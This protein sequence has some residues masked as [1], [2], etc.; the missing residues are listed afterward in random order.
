MPHISIQWKITSLGSICLLCTIALLVSSSLYRAEVNLDLVKSANMQMLEDA[1][2]ARMQARAE[3]QA[4]AIQHYFSDVHHFGYQ[5]SRQVAQLR[6]QGIQNGVSPD[7]VRRDLTQLVRDA[8]NSNPTLLSLYVVFQ[9]D[10][11]DNQDARF[12]GA[13]A[14]G[15]NEH[16]R[17]SS[18][19]TRNGANLSGVPVAEDKITD[20]TTMLDGSAYNAWYECPKQTFAPCLLDPYFDEASGQRVLTTSLVFPLLENGKLLAVVGADISLSRLQQ[21]SLDGNRLLYEGQGSVRIV[22]PAG[23]IA[24]DSQDA[25][26]LGQPLTQVLSGPSLDKAVAAQAS[27]TFMSLMVDDRLEM[28][29]PLQAIPNTKHWSVILQTPRQV[30]LAPSQQLEGE[31]DERNAKAAAWELA[32]G[33]CLALTAVVLLWLNARGVTRP[34]KHLS[35]MLREIANGEG[36]LTQRLH[37]RHEDE[38]G[39]LAGCF[40]RFLDKLQPIIHDVKKSVQQARATANKSATIS[41]R[42]STGMQQQFQDIEQV[43]TASQQMSATAQDVANSA[44]MASDAA[45]SADHATCDGLEMIEQTTK[46]I[47]TLAAQLTQS[48]ARAVSLATSG[49]QIGSVLEVIRSIAAQTNLLALNAAIEA[50]RAG[51]Q[52]RG[53]AVVADEVRSLARH[54]QDSVQ[55]IRQVIESLQL[56]THDM[57]NALQSSH[58]LAQDSVRQVGTAAD[59]LQRISEAVTVISDMNLQIA[60]AAEQQSAVAE[61]ITHNVVGIR[62]VTESLSSQAHES[63]SIGQSLNRLADHQQQ[64]MDHF[65]V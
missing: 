5:F 58:H 43:A 1:A 29:E 8:L 14:L 62:D 52:G 34:I 51:E 32:L 35:A 28:V 39:E 25:S 20:A 53:F 49:E 26:H 24:G 46:M 38:L 31:L 23:L 11:L 54:T 59:S 27:G 16:G 61:T 40:N 65:R 30:L 44:A 48:R 2:K 50:A 4:Q 33:V 9:P 15:S 63:A 22:S 36:D 37:Y 10:G 64:L 60:S 41:T 21:L 55:E 47:N 45:R 7:V 56:G 13:T 18:Y 19:W 42:T 57:A 12:K 17:F 6:M 3:Q